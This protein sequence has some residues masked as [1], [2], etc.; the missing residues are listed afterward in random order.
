MI[1]INNIINF[2]QNYKIDN[3][4]TFYKDA[5]YK[6]KD[7]KDTHIHKIKKLSYFLEPLRLYLLNNIDS[8]DFILSKYKYK[9]CTY[10]K[11]VL[12]KT[13]LDNFLTLIE[14][15]ETKKSNILD[16]DKI[17]IKILKEKLNFKKID[18]RNKIY[19]NIIKKK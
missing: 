6:L 8:Y 9:N 10:L 19:F 13:E 12:D 16:L 1:E 3:K 18:T 17:D 4:F 14:L 11:F 2:V 7:T 5:I 15:M